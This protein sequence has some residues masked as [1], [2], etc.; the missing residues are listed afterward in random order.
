M[1]IVGAQ[2]KTEEFG[3]NI[4]ESLVIHNYLPFGFQLQ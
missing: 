4:S 2:H 1:L 3:E